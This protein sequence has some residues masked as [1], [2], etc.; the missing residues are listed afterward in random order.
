MINQSNSET[1]PNLPTDQ[2][3]RTLKDGKRRRRSRNR[4][5]RLFSRLRRRF[6]FGIALIF[7]ITIVVSGAMIISA[8]IDDTTSRLDASW[9][10]L[11]RVLNNIDERQGSGITLQEFNRINL[12]VADL[13]GNI[14]AT[15]SQLRYVEPLFD[16]NDEWKVSSQL[17]GVASELTISISYMINGFEPVVNYLDGR[18]NNQT[19]S[20]MSS[21]ERIADLLETSQ[22]SFRYAARSLDQAQNQLNTIDLSE[23]PLD[24]VL[25]Y[26]Q[27]EFFYHQLQ[28]INSIFLASSDILPQLMGLDEE[29]TYL[30]LGLNNDTI[31][32]SGGKVEAYGWLNVWNGRI[33]NFDFSPSTFTNPL[34]PSPSFVNNISI[35]SWWIAYENPLYAAW[36]GSWYVDFTLTGQMALDYYNGAA[37]PNTPISGVI[38]VD[39]QTLEK[40]VGLL[41]DV[42]LPGPEKPVTAANLRST[43]YDPNYFGPYG[44]EDYIA[45]TYDT[46][47]RDLQDINQNQTA[48]LL[49]VLI[50]ALTQHHIMMYVSDPETQTFIDLLNWSGKQMVPDSNDYLLIGDTNLTNKSDHSIVRSLTYNVEVFENQSRRSDL[51]VRYDYF[52]TIASGDSA[53]NSE[54]FGDID[55]KTLTQVYLPPGALIVEENNTT[56]SSSVAGDDYTL[57]V[58]QL[59]VAYDSSEQFQIVYDTPI[60]ENKF[61]SLYRYSLFV[62]KQ[63]GIRTQEL[64]LQVKL[65]PNANLVWLSRMPES[66]YVLEQP[67]LDFRLQILADQWIEVLYT[68]G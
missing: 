10:R 55:Y 30:I 44:Y 19:G 59:D 21:G 27:I 15:Q 53:I 7:I 31:R 3:L 17:L 12:G 14:I 8:R 18:G 23:S 20:Q 52:N 40:L 13:R 62:E 56:E 58:T 57:F 4:F 6:S 48:T 37:N 28:D 42:T 49:T 54:Y 68:L 25:S 26:E 16:Y 11:E 5:Q 46:V 50:E 45:T 63:P 32:P 51:H 64:E 43:I 1:Q 65:P 66:Y 38:A 36:D 33:T 41:G 60:I 24:L 35:P 47:F 61:E 39:L 2:E 67:T 9:Q 29:V 34:P 22:V